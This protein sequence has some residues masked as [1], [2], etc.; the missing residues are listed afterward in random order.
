M[1]KTSIADLFGD[2][3]QLATT[4]SAIFSR[5][6]LQDALISRVTREVYASA[7]NQSIYGMGA[8]FAPGQADEALTSFYV[9]RRDPSV[10]R[11]PQDHPFGGGVEVDYRSTRP[12][13]RDDYTRQVW[14]Q[15]G[16][17]AR[18]R[19]LIWGPYRDQARTFI[20][21]E[22]AFYRNGTVAGVFSVDVLERDFLAIMRKNLV[23]GDVAA[24]V[25][26]NGQVLLATGAVP[27][28]RTHTYV[29]RVAMRFAP[30]THIVLF[31]DASVLYGGYRTIWFG[32]AGLLVV[33]WLIAA[34][35]GIGLL[36]RWRAHEAQLRLE[37]DQRRLEREIELSHAVETELR[38]VAYTDALTGLPNRRAFLEY[39]ASIVGTDRTHAVLFI[40][41]DRFNI[42][43]ETLGHMAGDE[44]L[45]IIGSRLKQFLSNE[46]M[47]ARLGGDEFVLAG[48]LRGRPSIDVMCS[49]LFAEVGQPI[50]VSGHSFFPEASIG[51]VTVDASYA[52]ADDI[53]RDA[54]IAMYEAKRRGRAGYVIFDAEMRRRIA[55]DTELEAAL[56][57]A[58]ERKELMP[59]YQ[60]VVRVESGEIAG[61]EALARWNRTGTIVAASEFMPFAEQHGLSAA[62]DAHMLQEV[63][64][65]SRAIY[66]LFPGTKIAVNVSAP[67]LA[68]PNLHDMVQLLRERNG[69]EGDGMV[70]EI[71]ETT[72]MTNPDVA[73]RTIERLRDL[74]IDFVLDD[75][76]T[77]YSSLAYL[78][79][80]PISGV[81]IDRSFVAPIAE[82]PKAS[83]IVRSIVMLARSFGLTTTAEGIETVRQ[84]EIVRDLGVDFA[85]GFFFSP[86][87]DMASLVRLKGRSDLGRFAVE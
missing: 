14:Y 23:R 58:L 37:G 77:G 38:R 42:V 32:T 19:T 17:A 64:Q 26:R 61:F 75:F 57:R 84:W 82:D 86:A 5:I 45:R 72:M 63:Y 81:K 73:V 39:A 59:F 71:T 12:S 18:G 7:L 1:V 60:P 20:S 66:D 8:F 25:A 50:I 51:V 79:H 76:G 9:R 41:L 53:L 4:G 55:N 43:N 28:D 74:Q 40:D 85:Q 70:F 22:R 2:G 46:D 29:S 54:D 10:G 56:R 13:P 65:H 15:R 68:S 67:E 48:P 69:R 47:I 30:H 80:L 87:I 21:I 27:A 83:E 16:L 24:I 33:I 49:R 34:L 62:I 3:F 6:P 78:Q 44:F 35:I 52:G 36:Q 11:S 31:S